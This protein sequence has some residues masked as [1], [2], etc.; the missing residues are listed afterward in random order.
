M[1]Y[2]SKRKNKKGGSSN[3]HKDY[4]K[5]I[6]NTKNKMNKLRKKQMRELNNIRQKLKIP[7]L[8]KSKQKKIITQKNRTII[9][10]GEYKKQ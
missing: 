10:C 1:K 9:N 3:S 2:L 8:S 5:M 7:Q 4:N 6:K